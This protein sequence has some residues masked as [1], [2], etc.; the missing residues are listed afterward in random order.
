MYSAKTDESLKELSRSVFANLSLHNVVPTFQFRLKF[1]SSVRLASFKATELFNF[2]NFLHLTQSTAKSRFPCR[3]IWLISWSVFPCV[4]SPAFKQFCVGFELK[5]WLIHPHP[6]NFEDPLFLSDPLQ[7]INVALFDL[8][9]Q[10]RCKP[11]SLFRLPANI[12][13]IVFQGWNSQLR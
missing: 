11:L 1:E 2:H 3:R 9:F 12:G 5:F 13:S 10:P 4:L 8:L 6:W 7:A